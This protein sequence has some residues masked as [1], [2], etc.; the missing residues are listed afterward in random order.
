MAEKE[1]KYYLVES[2]MVTRV[3]P[4]TTERL[5]RGGTWEDY[6]DRWRV[7][8]EGRRLE[9]EEKA[10]ATAQELWDQEDSWEQE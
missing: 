8:T 5:V 7:L 6:D 10:L 4:G 3:G 1:Y 2:Y 9:D